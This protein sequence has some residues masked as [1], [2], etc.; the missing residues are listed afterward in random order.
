MN[1][2]FPAL[3][4]DGQRLA[5]RSVTLEFPGD[6]TLRL[7]DGEQVRVVPLAG[8]VASSPLGHVPRFLR[9]PDG[10]TL[11]VPPGDD[12][13]AALATRRASSHLVALLHALESHSTAAATLTLLL[14]AAVSASLWLGLPALSRQVA[15]RLPVELEKKAGATAGIFFQQ[16]TTPG[17]FGLSQRRRAQ[18]PLD[19]LVAVRKLHVTPSLAIRNMG[20]PNAFALPGGTI[21]VSESLITLMLQQ[22]DGADLLAAVYAHEIAHIERRHG[23]QLVLRNSAALLVVAIV[24]GDLSTLTTF[25]G[26]L[27]FLLLQTGYA[28][29]FESEA[30]ADAVE[31]LRAAK[32][33][34]SALADA[35]AVLEKQRPATGADFTYLS[36]H[37]ST[38]D[39]IRVLRDA[40]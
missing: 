22:K 35:L 31:L 28:R 30:D 6:S 38:E 13:D 34:P 29:E 8:I 40:R 17:G 12:L 39:R 11:E 14:I 18:E 9:L 20:V 10:A 33:R 37:P 32:I 21:V 36:T 27:P 2:V 7:V 25:S 16:Q 5:S 26:T 19:R 3:F 4:C 24:T 1:Q 15:M 23:L